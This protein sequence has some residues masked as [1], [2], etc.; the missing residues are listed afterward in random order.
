MKETINENTFKEKNYFLYLNS[1]RKI[2][3]MKLKNLNL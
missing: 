3:V 2:M 1:A